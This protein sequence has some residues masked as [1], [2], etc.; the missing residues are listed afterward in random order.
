MTERITKQ[1]KTSADESVVP[2]TL[3][4]THSFAAMGKQKKRDK[5]VTNFLDKVI[6]DQNKDTKDIVAEKLRGRSIPLDNVK[7]NDLGKIRILV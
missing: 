6:E 1:Q 4:T 2:A 3:D 7:I 5:L